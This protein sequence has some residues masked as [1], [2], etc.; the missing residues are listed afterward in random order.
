[1]LHVDRMR[2]SI[3][4]YDGE[5]LLPLLDEGGRSMFAYWKE[6]KGDGPFPAKPDFDPMRVPRALPGIQI[7][8]AVG[9][10]DEFIYRLVGT[11]EVA[12]RGWDPTGKPIVDGF[13]GP[14][15]DVVLK[16]YRQTIENAVPLGVT[17]IFRLYSGIWKE[18]I[19]LFLPMADKSGKLTFVFVYSY[20]KPL[21]EG[22]KDQHDQQS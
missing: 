5:G 19:S 4:Y 14:S 21:P 15:A 3:R 12:A 10:P 1:M 22:D 7:V 18:D 8:E 16:H 9:K 17:G 6:L 11:R 20:Q 13:I 2:D